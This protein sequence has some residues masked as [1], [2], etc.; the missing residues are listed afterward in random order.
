[1]TNYAENEIAHWNRSSSLEA[2]YVVQYSHEKH[3]YKMSLSYRIDLCLW[4]T[5]LITLL[6]ELFV[7]FVACFLALKCQHTT[8]GK[9][10]GS[11]AG[12]LTKFRFIW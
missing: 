12:F 5:G 9:W 7:I 3:Q 6:T 11:L 10:D 4:R 8:L 2:A 1:M